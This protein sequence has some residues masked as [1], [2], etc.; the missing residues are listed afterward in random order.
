MKRRTQSRILT[1]D[2]LRCCFGFSRIRCSKRSESFK[3]TS[4]EFSGIKRANER[5]ERRLCSLS[6][7]AA[8]LYTGDL[9]MFIHKRGSRT[10]ES[11]D[12]W[13]ASASVAKY[14]RYEMGVATIE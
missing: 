4:T 10:W 14:Q 3:P 2:S 13:P 5:R 9:L 12:I 8:A 7:R 6:K 11:G 1:I